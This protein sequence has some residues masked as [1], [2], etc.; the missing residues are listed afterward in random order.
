MITCPTPLELPNQISCCSSILALTYNHLVRCSNLTIPVRGLS[1][2]LS[3]STH[4]NTSPSGITY[5]LPF[6]N[7]K[8]RTT[9]RIAD[10][11]PT[12]LAQFAVR[13][14]KP[15]EFDALSDHEPSDTD[16]G[17]SS[18]I[19]PRGSEEDEDERRWEWRFGLVLEDASE[20]K[21]VKGEER[22]RMEVYVAEQDAEFLL[23]LD[24]EEYVYR[25][26]PPPHTT[27]RYP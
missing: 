18:H 23:K 26:L 11:F 25:L 20:E 3:L 24:A 9:V 1:S 13:L 2:I 10:F 22:A 21:V 17:T 19:S 4:Q 8:S 6:Q 12:E 27:A 7:I 5:T 16:T 15:S 14:P